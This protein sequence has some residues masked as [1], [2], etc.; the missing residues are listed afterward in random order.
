RVDNCFTGWSRR[1][2]LDYPTHRVQLSASAACSQ[3]VCFLPG[4]GRRF[5]AIEPVTHVN[6]A[7]ALAASGVTGTGTRWL[8]AG[9]S[10][11]ASMSI[12]VAAT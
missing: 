3:V 10:L 7:F 4:D 1:A 6:N 11:E 8:K 2:F 12:Q 9:E 5:I